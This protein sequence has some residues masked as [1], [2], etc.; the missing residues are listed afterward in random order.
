MAAIPRPT[1][2]LRNNPWRDFKPG[3]WQSRINL[4]DFIQRNYAPHEGD[5]SFLASRG[6]TVF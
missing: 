5:R 1:E 4:R 6:L 3:A 2:E